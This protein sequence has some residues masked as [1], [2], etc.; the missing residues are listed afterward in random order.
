MTQILVTTTNI[1][2]QRV[3]TPGLAAFLIVLKK[4][5]LEEKPTMS[6]AH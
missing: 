6:S 2:M 4:T 5:F 1:P 3:V